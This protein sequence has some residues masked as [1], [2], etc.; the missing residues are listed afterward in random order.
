MVRARVLASHAT[1][2]APTGENTSAAPQVTL[3]EYE[4]PTSKISNVQAQ[5]CRLVEKNYYLNRSAR[6]AYRAY[7]LAYASHG[8]KDVFDVH[9][10]DLQAVA[11]AF[12]FSVPPKV[13]LAFSARGGTRVKKHAKGGA[14][15]GHKFSAENPYGKRAATDQR[16]FTH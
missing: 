9:E 11:S 13:D 16:Q 15:S 1:V 2:L 14:Q 8:L 12:G 3:N 6:D 5:L 4:F 7:L 10:L